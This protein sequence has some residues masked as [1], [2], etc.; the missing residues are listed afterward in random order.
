MEDTKE[1]QACQRLKKQM[2]ARNEALL[3][4]QQ[5]EEQAQTSAQQTIDEVVAG[6]ANLTIVET[7][8]D[9]LS[10]GKKGENAVG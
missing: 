4:P 8:L 3:R 2:T 5:V 10:V 1:K 9:L 6:T 7:T